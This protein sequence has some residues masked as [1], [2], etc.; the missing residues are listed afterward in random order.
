MPKVEGMTQEMLFDESADARR[1]CRLSLSGERTDGI[2][3]MSRP[4]GG[5]YK[6]YLQVKTQYDNAIKLEAVF[7]PGFSGDLQMLMGTLV[8]ATDILYYLVRCRLNPVTKRVQSEW[9]M[10]KCFRKTM[11][12]MTE[13]M[14]ERELAKVRDVFCMTVTRGRVAGGVKSDGTMYIR[15]QDPRTHRPDLEVLF[16]PGTDGGPADEPIIHPPR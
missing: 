3:G 13:S 6:R 11:T 4:V 16:V 1:F 10:Y 15:V 2:I 12:K 7:V 5:T 14:L 8:D 9:P